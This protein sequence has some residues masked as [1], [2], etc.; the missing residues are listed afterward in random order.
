MPYITS[1]EQ[2][3]YDRGIKEGQEE[4]AIAIA[5]NLLRKN[6]DVETIV[7]VTGTVDQSD[8][9]STRSNE[10]RRRGGCLILPVLNRLATIGAR[11][12]NENRSPSICCE[13][14]WT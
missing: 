8:S 14:A 12:R 2:I 11:L 4:K 9:I 6:L 1:V 13:K 5:L 10:L 7:E 3:G